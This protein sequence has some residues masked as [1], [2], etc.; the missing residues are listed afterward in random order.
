VQRK[1]S[2][3]RLNNILAVL[4]KPLKYAMD[5]ERI[6][7]VPKIGLYKVEQYARLLAAARIEGPDW[8]AAA[9]LAGE[10]G[11]RRRRLRTA[12]RGGRSR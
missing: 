1:L 7:R 12:V 10:A 2:E 4:S 3:K 8:Y 11:L 9:C 5:C 6:A